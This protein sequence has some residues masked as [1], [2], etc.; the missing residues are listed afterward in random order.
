[1]EAEVERTECLA[2]GGMRCTYAIRA[3]RGDTEGVSEVGRAAAS[4]ALEN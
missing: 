3:R 2:E 1:M 4:G